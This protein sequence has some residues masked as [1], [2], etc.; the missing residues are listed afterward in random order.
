ML[1]NFLI[2]YLESSKRLVVPQL[3]VFL[4]KEPGRSIV[5]SELMKRD[6]GVLRGLLCNEGKNE[7]EAAGMIDRFV[8]EV[9]HAVENGTDYRIPGFGTFK[10]G[11]NGAIRFVCQSAERPVA[12]LSSGPDS[13]P[14]PKP[15]Q[16]PEPMLNATQVPVGE[17]EFHPVSKSAELKPHSVEK[18]VA[19]QK[20]ESLRAPVSDDWAAYKSHID[21]ARMAETMRTAFGENAGNTAARQPKRAAARSYAE[22]DA[23]MSP[24]VRRPKR[25]GFDRFFLFVG[26]LAV[27]IAVAAIAFGFWR[28]ISERQAEDTV[29]VEEVE[30]WIPRSDNSHS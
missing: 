16:E 27:L 28:E 11:L 9:R 29:E 30:R 12:A 13:Q 22:D 3:G 20:K 25:R 15:I 24:D 17:P 14:I 7:I 26:I 2:K 21:T 10:P 23:E 5:F 6:D 18:P 1:H 4:V 19:P 8:F